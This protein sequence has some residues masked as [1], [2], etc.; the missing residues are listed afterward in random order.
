MLWFWMRKVFCWQ[1]LMP[2]LTR[3]TIPQVWECFGIMHCWQSFPLVL[4]IVIAFVVCLFA[5]ISFL[6]NFLSALFI[7]CLPLG[8][9]IIYCF[10]LYLLYRLV[11][12]FL[13]LFWYLLKTVC[14]LL[15]D[16]LAF[17]SNKNPVFQR[18]ARANKWSSCSVE[19]L[20]P[21]AIWRLISL[22]DS[23]RSSF[24]GIDAAFL[25]HRDYPPN[26]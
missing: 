6:F 11:C 12:L 17:L 24:L 3:S 26:T 15:W 23:L 8:S 25:F 14:L 7:C 2:R 4:D 16:S 21:L 5:Y 1:S 20:R 18:F 9:F 22:N 10:L 13:F 19:S